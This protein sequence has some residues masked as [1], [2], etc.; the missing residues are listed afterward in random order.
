VSLRLGLTNI[1]PE[2]HAPL[3]A[4]LQ[5]PHCVGLLGGLPSRALYIAGITEQK[6]LVGLDPHYPLPLSEQE[7]EPFPSEALLRQVFDDDVELL[8]ASHMDASLAAAFLFPE[9][10][11]FRAWAQARQAIPSNPDGAVLFSVHD[12]RPNTS[13][14]VDEEEEEE[15][16]LTADVTQRAMEGGGGGGGDTETETETETKDEAENEAEADGFVLV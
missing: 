15:G 1:N 4:A 10:E 2:Y 5:E 16:G 7:K 12:T 9:Y 14:V 3:H 11:S 6:Q 8:D 13:A